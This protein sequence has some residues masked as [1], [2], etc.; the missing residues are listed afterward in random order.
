MVTHQE[1]DDAR[2][3]KKVKESSSELTSA[4]EVYS[5]EFKKLDLGEQTLSSPIIQ[6]HAT[7]ISQYCILKAPI[8]HP[9]HVVEHFIIFLLKLAKNKKI[10]DKET[11]LE[12]AME[13]EMETR[14]QNG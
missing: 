4:W 11:F 6:Y 14:V 5:K 10:R 2:R 12:G 9:L 8:E 1:M 3:R 13:A 7:I